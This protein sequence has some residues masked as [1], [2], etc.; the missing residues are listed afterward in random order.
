MCK[1]MGQVGKRLGKRVIAGSG[2]R[3]PDEAQ[4]LITGQQDI[5]MK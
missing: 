2:T 1:K 4:P 5:N 3:Y